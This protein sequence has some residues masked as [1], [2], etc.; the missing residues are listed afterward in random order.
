MKENIVEVLDNKKEALSLIE[1]NDLLELKTS[2]ELQDLI[3]NLNELVEENIVYLTKKEKYILYKNC[4]NFKIGKLSLTKKG[5]GF[6]VL[7]GDDLYI[8]CENMKDAI[9]DD[10]VLCEEL[11]SSI[12]KEG[13][14][15]KVLKR[16]LKNL[17]GEIHIIDNEV[18]VELADEKRKMD[19][20]LDQASAVNC[21]DGT[22]VVVKI[23]KELGN[24]KYY[25]RVSNIL[26]HKNDPGVDI[27]SIAYKYG[28]YNE[29]SK[30]TE[31]QISNIPNDVL[32]KELVGRKDLTDQVIFTIDGDD[33]KDIDDAISIEKKDNIYTLG[34][35]I[36]DV[37]HYVTENSPLDNDAFSRGTSSYLA[38]TVIP[39]LPHKL[40][41]GIC[42]LNPNIV[43]LT[44]S[45]VMKIDSNGKIID[46][47]IFQ[48]YIKSRKQMTYKCVNDILMRNVVRE[49]YKE[50]SQTLLLMN[51]LAH[52][53]RKEKI[54][55]GY[56][57]FGIDEN[58]IIQDESGKAIDVKKRIR[59]DGE[60]L[61]E[62]FMIAANETIASHIYN[63][64]LPFIYRDHDIPNP[65]KI[66]DFMKLVQLLGYNLKHKPLKI[67]S[68]SM[69][70]MLNELDEVKEFKMLSSI[71]LRSM[72]KADYRIENIGHFGLASK[73]YTHFTSPIRRYPDLIVHRLLRR[74]L[75]NGDISNETVRE[76]E[77]KL[78][79]IALQCSEREV[80]AVEAERDV[81]DMKSAEYME[82]YVGEEFNGYI[83]GLTNFGM[84]VE[85]ENL[86]EGL[87]HVS[88]LKGDYYEYI[89]ELFSMVGKSTKKTYRLG[90][91]V[92]VKLVAASKLTSTID[93][94]IVEALKGDN[95]GNKQ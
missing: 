30:E 13:M 70:E 76:L 82:S 85:L 83:S 58:K 21:V 14:V 88:S 57:D 65:E 54:S 39:M 90:S 49:D 7:P 37:S 25:V 79:E 84:F 26:G 42:S 33:T 86:I 16:D 64:N 62:D 18:V 4:S 61:I 80:A 27:L 55:R 40:S 59:E 94:E 23:V 89:P 95:D 9:H 60:L 36:A 45:C 72:K 1:I 66:E 32:E 75:F 43:R 34:V 24:N 10:I 3:K 46:Y 2:N 87:I 56:I 81:T 93:F 50:F 78:P 68:L 35:H 71:L 19:L 38:D 8:S 73:N 92:R 31:E 63:M 20:E 17:V 29:F 67:T 74:Y 77:V 48:S 28:I 52:I 12:R 6:V 44:L 69:Q 51:E 5:Y 53:L 22:K 91:E 41:N 15:L 11:K 47:D